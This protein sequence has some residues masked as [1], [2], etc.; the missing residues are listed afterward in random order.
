MKLSDL[1]NEEV[2]LIFTLLKEVTSEL[3]EM[4]QDKG[5]EHIVD[6]PVGKIALFLKVEEDILEEMRSSKKYKML[7]NTL[8]KFEPVVDIITDSYPNLQTDIEEMLFPSKNN[9][10]TD[11][12]EGM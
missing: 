5:I 9:N 11:E 3:N 7:T 1:D 6:T 4:L 2:M 8:R 12:E 10:N